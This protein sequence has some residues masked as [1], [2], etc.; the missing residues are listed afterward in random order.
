MS[1]E[2]VRLGVGFGVLFTVLS[3]LMVRAHFPGAGRR[4]QRQV[5]VLYATTGVCVA[6][7]FWLAP[8]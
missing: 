8:A 1:G 2:D 7:F 3:P 4:F 5:T 6:L